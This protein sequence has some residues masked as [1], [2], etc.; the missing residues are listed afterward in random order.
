MALIL[1]ELT[2]VSF[3]LYEWITASLN[4]GFKAMMCDGNKK[5]G[6]RNSFLFDYLF[7]SSN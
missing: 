7:I 5:E 4:A 1:N 3:K 2:H 6:N